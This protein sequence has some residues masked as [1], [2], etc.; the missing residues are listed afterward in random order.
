MLNKL[1]TTI[2]IWALRSKR[3]TREQR[4][5]VMT[6]LLDNLGALPIR[7]LVARDNLGRLLINGK[8]MD[9]VEQ[10]L[11]FRQS[12]MSYKDNPARKMLADQKKFLALEMG[13]FNGLNP[14]MIQFSKAVLYCIE[15]DEK[16]I[17]EILAE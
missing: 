7:K 3:L 10:L 12:L 2:T 1:I 16:I 11:A 17:D 6:V 5:K 4:S 9:D 13:V 14:E 15:Q 8:P